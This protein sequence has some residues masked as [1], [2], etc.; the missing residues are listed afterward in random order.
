LLART[1]EG[2]CGSQQAKIGG[3]FAYAPKK[4]TTTMDGGIVASVA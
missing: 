4:M 1:V 2:R 3:G